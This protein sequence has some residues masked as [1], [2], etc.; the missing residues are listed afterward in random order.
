[1]LEI[2]DAIQG[3]L[4]THG[5]LQL[6][7]RIVWGSITIAYLLLFNDLHARVHTRVVAHHDAAKLPVQEG[8]RVAAHWLLLV[9][10]CVR[11]N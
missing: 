5:I 1:M 11:A 9:V 6:T 4:T 3:T 7:C 10:L 8:F 2:L